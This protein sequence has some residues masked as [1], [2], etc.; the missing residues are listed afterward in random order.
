MWTLQGSM[1]LLPSSHVEPQSIALEK[2]ITKGKLQF[3]HPSRTDHHTVDG[4]NPAPR[5]TYKTM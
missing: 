3:H 4:R 2:K 5:G 1:R